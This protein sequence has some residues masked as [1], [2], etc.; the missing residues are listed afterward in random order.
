MFE[1]EEKAGD[2]LRARKVEEEEV[3]ALQEEIE[4]LRQQIAAAGCA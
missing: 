2:A 3:A 1:A 4:S